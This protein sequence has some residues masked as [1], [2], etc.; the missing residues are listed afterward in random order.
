MIK[1]KSPKDGQ[2][3]KKEGSKPQQRPK[4][5][6]DIRIAKYKEGRA[7]IRGRENRTIQNTKSDSLVSLS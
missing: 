4:A 2:W 3:Q 1:P 7:S 6:F 5:T